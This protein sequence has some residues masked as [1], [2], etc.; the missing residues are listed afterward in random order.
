M[1][2]TIDDAI[3]IKERVEQ[4]S[5]SSIIKHAQMVYPNECCGF[6]LENG[7]IQSAQ[8]VIHNLY[9]KSLTSRNA[10]LI[11]GQSWH[12]ASNRESPIIGIY[13]SHTNG[14]SNMSSSDTTFLKWDSHYYL[15]IALTD[16]NPVSSK[17]FWW[18]NAELKELKI[19]L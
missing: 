9:D 3:K 8:N 10:F 6:I 12:I 18:E 11:D 19:K 1:A 17:L 15:I 2:F 7:S 16:S 14:D 5:I 13:H 4:I